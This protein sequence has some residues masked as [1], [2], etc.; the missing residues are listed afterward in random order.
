MSSN[1]EL[2][3]GGDN[4]EFSGAEEESSSHDRDDA[5][6]SWPLTTAERLENSSTERIELRELEGELR[7]TRTE[8]ERQRGEVDSQRRALVRQR[9][10]IELD[11]REV[12]AAERSL[13][14][15]L[16]TSPSPRDS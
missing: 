8:L 2:E 4:V 13:D 11:Q 9:A 12:R 6:P 10:A 14:C 7:A 15:L 5:A 16:Y 3:N 1:D